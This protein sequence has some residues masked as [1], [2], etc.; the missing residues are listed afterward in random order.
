VVTRTYAPERGDLV[1][2]DFD[3]QAGPEQAGRRPAFVVSPAFYNVKSGL[4][5]LCPV[6]SRVKGYPFEVALPEGLEIQGV[7]LAD[8]VR[9]VD[10][11]ARNWVFAERMPEPI[12]D[13]VLA[14]IAPLVSA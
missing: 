7:V 12:I 4:A 9:S 13:Q 1:W 3:P 14:R 10:W 8:Q 2:I 5:L 6:T 11:R